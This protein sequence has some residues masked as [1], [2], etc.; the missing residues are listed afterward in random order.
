LLEAGKNPLGCNEILQSDLDFVTYMAAADN[1]LAQLGQ[2]AAFKRTVPIQLGGL[3]QDNP[4]VQKSVAFYANVFYDLS[5]DTK[6]TFGYRVNED[7]YDDYA[8]NALGDVLNPDYRYSP[9]YDLYTLAG[10][11]EESNEAFRTKGENTAE[12]FKLAIQH[13]LNDDTMVY[14]SYSTGNKPGGSTPD[15]YGNASVFAPETVDSFE[16]GLRSILMDGRM[17]MNLTAFS[18]EF[19][20]AHTSQVVG[21]AAITNSLDYTHNGLEGQMRFFVNEATSIDFNF[22]ALDST[23]DDGE[24]LFNPLNPNGAS[25]ILD[26]YNL[27]DEDD[28]A[29]MALALDALVADGSISS[30]SLQLPNPI[31]GGGGDYTC[32]QLAALGSAAG[33]AGVTAATLG[34]DALI[35]G[36]GAS[37]LGLLTSNPDAGDLLPFLLIGLTDT[38]MIANYQGRNL[39]RGRWVA[40]S[41]AFEALPLPWLAA[42]YLVPL[43]GTR[44][45]FTSELDYNI[46]VNHSMAVMSG[47]LDLKLTYSHK[48]DTNGDLFD[49][50]LT[51]VPEQ[52]Y[53]DLYGNWTPNDGDY[54]VGF[55]IKNL[56]DSRN[57]AGSRTTS[58]MVGGPANLYF[59]QPRTAGLTFGLNF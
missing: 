5:D 44:T 17:L 59:T 13:N 4:V 10:T 14:A 32:E 26:I 58:E 19:Q 20:D 12:T 56:E 16:L 49:S 37:Y 35:G 55:Y 29:R 28:V 47:M 23:I 36:T 38:G 42:D 30:Q 18:M 53:L 31:A 54:Y 15:Q 22:L 3:I 46:A 21:S 41:D 50:P 40:D 57:L 7:K 34:C 43:G 6:L 45:P 52:D 11:V 9:V 1:L 24:E 27:T 48:G 8:F 2:P 25:E 39:S 33:V 51:Y